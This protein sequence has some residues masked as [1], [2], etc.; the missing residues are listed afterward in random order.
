MTILENAILQEIRRYNDNDLEVAAMGLNNGLELI[1]TKP[2]YRYSYNRREYRA[3]YDT[4]MAKYNKERDEIE[5][6]PIAVLRL[7]AKCKYNPS[8]EKSSTIYYYLLIN[9]NGEIIVQYEGEDETVET[10]SV[11]NQRIMWKHV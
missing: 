4:I 7:K 3:C 11:E 5:D 6:T 9:T 2:Y 1:A 8:P 10:E